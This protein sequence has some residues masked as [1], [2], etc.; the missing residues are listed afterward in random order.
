[1]GLSWVFRAAMVSTYTSIWKLRNL[2]HK[3][4]KSDTV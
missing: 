4:T 2:G 1:L 3:S